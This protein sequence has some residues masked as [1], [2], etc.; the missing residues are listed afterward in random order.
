M[1]GFK[2]PL[3]IK[4]Q[5]YVDF[6][7]G[8]TYLHSNSLKDDLLGKWSVEILL[9][10]DKMRLQHKWSVGIHFTWRN[11]ITDSGRMRWR[12]AKQQGGPLGVIRVNSKP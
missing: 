7:F 1:N 9:Y 4:A 11:E 10:K 8:F 5:L 3:W 2:R 6:N 12:C